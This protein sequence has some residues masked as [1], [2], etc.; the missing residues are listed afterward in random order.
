[1]LRNDHF[2]D[3][4]SMTAVCSIWTHT[5]INLAGRHGIHLY[6]AMWCVCQYGVSLACS[7]EA[8][9]FMYIHVYVVVVKGFE[10]AVVC[11]TPVP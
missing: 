4:S 5:F 3:V 10:T 6:C 9:P 11:L 7:D 8:H 1:M 2:Y